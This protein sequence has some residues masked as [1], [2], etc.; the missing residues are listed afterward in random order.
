MDISQNPD[1]KHARLVEYLSH[2]AGI[3]I[4]RGVKVFTFAHRTFQEYLAACYLTNDDFPGKIAKLARRE[5]NRWREVVLLAGAKAARGSAFAIGALVDE[6][7][8]GEPETVKNR[9]EGAWGAHLAAQAIVETADLTKMSD[10]NRKKVT[11]IKRC[12]ENVLITTGFP[13]RERAAAGVNLAQLGDERQDVM[14]TRA[15]Q[16]CLVPKGSFWMGEDVEGHENDALAYDF[17]I[18]RYPVTQ[19]QFLEF[20]KDGGYKNEKYWK[21]AKDAGMWRDGEI[22]GSYDDKSRKEPYQYGSPFTLPNHPVVGVTWYEVLAFTRWL[23]DRWKEQGVLPEGWAVRLP[24]EAE[25]EKAARGGREIPD[26][27]QIISIEN[28]KADISLPMKKNKAP[29]RVYPWGNDPDSNRANYDEIGIGA[30]SAVGCFPGGVSPY[31]CEEMSGNVWEWTRS[32]SRKYPYDPKDGRENLEA[33]EADIRVVR[34]GS[35][36]LNRWDVRCSCRRMNY[37]DIRVVSIFIGFRVM[38][39]P[40]ISGR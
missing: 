17:W 33:P 36:Y 39:S 13:P 40:F 3:L 28:V 30:T 31:G 1:V 4:P 16:F 14:T 21:E 29:Q 6:L 8:D 12:L 38:L 23:T 27:L 18:S 2:R 22:R 11:R 25:W 9:M 37:N 10:N 26:R 35:F 5:P 7:C 19:A 20:I 24:S 15:M 32:L 34:G